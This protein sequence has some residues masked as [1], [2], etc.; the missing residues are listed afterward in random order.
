VTPK[1]EREVKRQLELARGRE[2]A[3]RN[4]KVHIIE[5]WELEGSVEIIKTFTSDNDSRGDHPEYHF[6][7]AGQ[8][9]TAELPNNRH[10]P[11]DSLLARLM[12]AIEAL[13]PETKPVN[14]QELNHSYRERMQSQNY[15]R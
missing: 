9:V 14:S 13:Q 10:Y 2:M 7:V 4:R 3:E 11:S 1:E 5:I 8:F 6:Y 15:R 12:L